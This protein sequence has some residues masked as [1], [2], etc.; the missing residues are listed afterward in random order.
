MTRNIAIALML[1]IASALVGCASMG[2]GSDVSV[3]TADQDEQH[4]ELTTM[5]TND[6]YIDAEV[7]Y[8]AGQGEEVA[9]GTF[10]WLDGEVVPA[11]LLDILAN[12]PDAIIIDATPIASEPDTGVVAQTVWAEL[13]FQTLEARGFVLDAHAGCTAD[14]GL[15]CFEQ[16]LPFRE[17][18]PSNIPGL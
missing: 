8:S 10:R 16:G 12:I 9:Q 3:V 14:D 11:E 5:Q 6:G 13:Q 18:V 2:D 7:Y 4:F 17:R 15:D 1:A